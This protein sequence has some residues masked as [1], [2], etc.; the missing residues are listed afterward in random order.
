MNDI[1]YDV[2]HCVTKTDKKQKVKQQYKG[3]FTVS[4]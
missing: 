1:H 3:E 2:V 4:L